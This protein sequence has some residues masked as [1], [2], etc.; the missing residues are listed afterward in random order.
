M[1]LYAYGELIFKACIKICAILVKKLEICQ[2]RKNAKFLKK[3]KNELWQNGL[4]QAN[5]ISHAGTC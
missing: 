4:S 3:F 2:K 5:E 1:K